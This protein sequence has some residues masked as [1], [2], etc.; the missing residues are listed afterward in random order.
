MSFSTLLSISEFAAYANGTFNLTSSDVCVTG[1]MEGVFCGRRRRLHFSSSIICRFFSSWRFL[2]H[3]SERPTPKN[4]SMKTTVPRQMPTASFQFI[5]MTRIKRNRENPCYTA[6][7]II[8][9]STAPTIKMDYARIYKVL[10]QN[11]IVLWYKL[12]NCY[13][14][15][16]KHYIEIIGSPRTRLVEFSGPSCTILK[17][18]SLYMLLSK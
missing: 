2:I 1:R 6:V 4:T 5:A 16:S 10:W 17:L 11:A 18:C 15:R 12:S 13:I 9:T 7:H 14:N 3:I 8:H